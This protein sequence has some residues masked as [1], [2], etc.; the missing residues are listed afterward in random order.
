MMERQM[1]ADLCWRVAWQIAK[2][3]FFI[4]IGIAGTLIWTGR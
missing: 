3:A 4:G 2:A 1:R